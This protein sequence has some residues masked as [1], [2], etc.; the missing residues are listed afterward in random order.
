M[1]EC[2]RYTELYHF[3]DGSVKLHF[4]HVRIM[5]ELKTSVYGTQQ[6]AVYCNSTFLGLT[7]AADVNYELSCRRTYQR[8]KWTLCQCWIYDE[9][10]YS[11]M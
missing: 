10:C 9:I 8:F 2:V 1:A 6:L 3:L 4:Y 5:K 7:S 11:L